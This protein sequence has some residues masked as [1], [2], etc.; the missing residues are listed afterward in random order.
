VAV[1]CKARH[2]G[3]LSGSNSAKLLVYFP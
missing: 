2:S 1:S 3:M